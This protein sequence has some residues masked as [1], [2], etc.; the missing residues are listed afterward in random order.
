MFPPIARRQRKLQRC[1]L[2]AAGALLLAVACVPAVSSAAPPSLA[3][4]GA[5]AA[6]ARS[7]APAPRALS[8]VANNAVIDIQSFQYSVPALTI[9][10]GTTVTWTNFDVEPHTVTARNRAF[11]SPGLETGDTFAFRFD[12]PGTY[13]YYCAL[14]PHMTGQIVVQ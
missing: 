3:A 10:P 7:A 6:P 8:E 9:P 14:H 2:P 13:A 12:T 4:A 1:V 5:P 11:N